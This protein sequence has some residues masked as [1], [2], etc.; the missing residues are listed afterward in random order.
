MEAFKPGDDIKCEVCGVT[1]RWIRRDFPLLS[2]HEVCPL[3]SAAPDML[4]ALKDIVREKTLHGAAV[5]SMKAVRD[6][7]AK[8]E[9]K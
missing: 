5:D 4:E 1:R 2:F 7:I 3:H 9:G 6:A 8:V